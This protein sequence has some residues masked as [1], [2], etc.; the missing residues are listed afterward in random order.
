M[1]G[2]GIL[3]IIGA[4]TARY[5]RQWDPVWFYL[6]TGIQ[7]L[8]FGVGLAGVI[9]GFVLDN[10]LDADVSTHK[11]LGIFILVLGCLQVCLSYII[12][13]YIKYINKYTQ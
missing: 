3:V 13:S 8:G 11:A 1:L 10:H 5:L 7:S 9:C 2:W 12:Y 4:I 6:H